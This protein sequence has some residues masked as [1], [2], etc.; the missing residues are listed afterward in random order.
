MDVVVVANRSDPEPGYV[1]ERLEALGGRLRTA[2]REQPDRLA[3]A[4]SGADLLVLLGSEWSVARPQQPAAVAAE[5][6]LVREALRANRPVLAICYGAQLAASALGAAVERLPLRE[7]GW[8]TIDTT[9]PVL[10]PAGP[11]LELHEDRWLAGPTVPSLATTAAG[12]QAF[13]AGRLVAWQFHP[14]VTQ[15]VVAR[16]VKEIA[17]ELGGRGVDPDAL[18]AESAD[19]AADARRR[20]HALVDAVLG[21]IGAVRQ[22]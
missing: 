1:G 12:P 20:C 16:W 18:I 19:R 17:D 9:D 5:Q 6:Q 14:E 13:M 11:W 7:T 15:D 8:L 4:A 10:A 22:G 3:G 21:R 2:L